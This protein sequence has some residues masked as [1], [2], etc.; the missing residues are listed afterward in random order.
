MT[1]FREIR[2]CME[3]K[4]E[5]ETYDGIEVNVCKEC[6]DKL[7]K[8]SVLKLRIM[9]IIAVLLCLPFGL[10]SLWKIRKLKNLIYD[11][12]LKKA[13]KVIR[14]IWIL[15]IISYIIFLSIGIKI[16]CELFL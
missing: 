9:A 14:T 16:F 2:I 15:N 7:N 3:C 13:R 10:I 5:F 11:F 12:K 8:I 6:L 1:K 4:K